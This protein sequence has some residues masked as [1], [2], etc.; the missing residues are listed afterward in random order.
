M[1]RYF[2][3]EVV[4]DQAVGVCS[5]IVLFFLF[6]LELL[7][8]GLQVEGCVGEGMESRSSRQIKHV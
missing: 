4:Q 2:M 3:T 7:L 8:L 1:V 6:T 5:G